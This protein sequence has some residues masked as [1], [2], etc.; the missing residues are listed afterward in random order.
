[1]NPARRLGTIGTR[2]RA[3]THLYVLSHKCVFK[4]AL[5]AP[6]A[7]AGVERA[8]ARTFLMR[9]IVAF[10]YKP[11]F[12]HQGPWQVWSVPAYDTIKFNALP[13]I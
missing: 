1:M 4:A 9:L 13:G 12:R 6:G 7:L 10:L 3:Y 2:L 11:A 8:T 5:Q